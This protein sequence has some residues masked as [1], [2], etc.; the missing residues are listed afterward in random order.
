MAYLISMLVLSSVSTLSTTLITDSLM[1][2]RVCACA[3]GTTCVSLP[4]GS[5]S[6]YV[7]FIRYCV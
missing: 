5:M 1:L 4:N 7:C 2:G 6:V 3:S